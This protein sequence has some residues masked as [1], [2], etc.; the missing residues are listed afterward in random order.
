M[1]GGFVTGLRLGVLV[2]ACD[3]TIRSHSGRVDTGILCQQ[4]VSACGVTGWL[5]GVPM[6]CGFRSWGWLSARS[7]TGG[8]RNSRICHGIWLWRLMLLRSATI[9][10]HHGQI[11]PWFL[12]FRRLVAFRHNALAIDVPGMNALRRT[13]S[14]DGVCCI[15]SR[16][17]ILADC[18]IAGVG[19]RK[20]GTCVPPRCFSVCAFA[21]LIAGL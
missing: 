18:P 4:Q 2:S 15:E 6:H 1:A 3:V 17:G 5:H 19:R 12:P 13:L 8:S 21:K 20:S 11:F 9:R 7:A 16:D 10:S 14:D